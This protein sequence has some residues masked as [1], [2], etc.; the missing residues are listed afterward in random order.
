MTIQEIIQ[1]AQRLSLSDQ[2][3]LVSQLIQLL[4]HA[5]QTAFTVPEPKTEPQIEPLPA[6]PTAAVGIIA[7]LIKNPIPFN[8]GP[9]TREEIYD[10]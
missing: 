4:E 3:H 7:D 1:Q 5:M 2:M 10:R 9:L 6:S 8:G